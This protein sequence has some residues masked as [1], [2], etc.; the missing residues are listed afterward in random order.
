M[1]N[2]C[3]CGSLMIDDLCTNKNC[4]F[5]KPATTKTSKPKEPKTA[6]ETP[7]KLGGKAKTAY[8]KARRSSRCITYSI[9]ELK[10]NE[11]K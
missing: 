2:F 7:V 11:D 3:S 1:V 4:S 5:H 10:K 8:E 6:K 9:D